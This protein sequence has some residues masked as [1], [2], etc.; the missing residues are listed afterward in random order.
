MT[1]EEE[2]ELQY[3]VLDQF[4]FIPYLES[5]TTVEGLMFAFEYE[6]DLN[7]LPPEFQ[8]CVFNYINTEDFAN[9]LANRYPQYDFFETTSWKINKNQFIE[10]ANEVC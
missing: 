9:Y 8:N 4:D 1:Y 3:K 6:C 10:Y 7:L 5:Y 2:M